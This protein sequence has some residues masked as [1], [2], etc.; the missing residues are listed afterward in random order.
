VAFF[1][2]PDPRE[3][4]LAPVVACTLTSEDL[5]TQA[6]R[7]TRLRSEAGLERVETENGLRLSFRDERWVEEELRALVAVEND[8]CAWASWDVRPEP[9]E[10]VMHASSTGDGV[11]T[12]HGMFKGDRTLSGSG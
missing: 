10:L 9:G 7:W 2:T 12:L 1:E 6:E 4:T 3:S 8:C 11:T 5:G